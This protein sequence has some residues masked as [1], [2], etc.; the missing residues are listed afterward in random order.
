MQSPRHANGFCVHC[1]LAGGP[2]FMA[3]LE[4]MVRGR[5]N[6]PS[7]VQWDIFNEASPS[8]KIV[9]AS[10]AAIL[11]LDPSR[12]VDACSGCRSQKMWWALSDVQDFVRP[13]PSKCSFAAP[14]L[15]KT[16][17]V[18]AHRHGPVGGAEFEQADRVRGGA[19][20]RLRAAEGPPLVQQAAGGRR[21]LLGDAR[22]GLRPGFADLPAV[23]DGRDRVHQVLW[24]LGHRL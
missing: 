23:G 19:P 12:P 3:E 16:R 7:I 14:V 6:H 18:P 9:A 21:L 17:C 2:T 15:T 22:R 5:R 24:A 20:L 10:R 13:L 11:R 4:A 1:R 8:Q